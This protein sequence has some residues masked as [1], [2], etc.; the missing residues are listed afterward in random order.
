[1]YFAFVEVERA[2]AL[3]AAAAKRRDTEVRRLR[4]WEAKKE[5]DNALMLSAWKA[6]LAKMT[7][8]YTPNLGKELGIGSL[9]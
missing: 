4:H 2:N 7:G 8:R 6:K 3:G 5:S 9:W 1:M